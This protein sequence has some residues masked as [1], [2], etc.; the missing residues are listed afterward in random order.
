MIS[1]GRRTING[2]TLNAERSMYFNYEGILGGSAS[3]GVPSARNNWYLA[4]GY[5]GGDF[6][7]WVL[8]QNPGTNDARVTMKFQLQGGSA[9]DN[10]FD[11]P[12]GTRLVNVN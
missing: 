2:A 12:A 8:V 3:I 10:V 4:E 6:D 5:T 1:D 11:L 9:P 7:T